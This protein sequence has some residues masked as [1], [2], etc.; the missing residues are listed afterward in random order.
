MVV[1]AKELATLI[2]Y[3]DFAVMPDE[4]ASVASNGFFA[5]VLLSKT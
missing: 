1:W 5:S 3:G 4:E 2:K